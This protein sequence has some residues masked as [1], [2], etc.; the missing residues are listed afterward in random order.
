M[1]QFMIKQQIAF[2]LNKHDLMIKLLEF[3]EKH[4]KQELGLAEYLILKI[5]SNLLQSIKELIKDASIYY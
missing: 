2:I 1:W 5:L 3:Y 4:L